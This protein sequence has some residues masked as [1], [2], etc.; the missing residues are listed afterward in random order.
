MDKSSLSVGIISLTALRII[1]IEISNR[2][3]YFNDDGPGH[4]LYHKAFSKIRSVSLVTVL[5]D[6]VVH[7]V[8][9][10]LIVCHVYCFLLLG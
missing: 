8:F 10:N 3:G 4:I 6:D 9:K 1:G 7:G 5:K 2:P